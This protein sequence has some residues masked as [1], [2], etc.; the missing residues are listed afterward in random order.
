MLLSTD[1][2]EYLTALYDFL[3]REHAINLA[4]PTTPAYTFQE[5]PSIGKMPIRTSSPKATI[6]EEGTL[7]CK[8]TLSHESTPLNLLQ[9]IQAVIDPLE[10]YHTFS[11]LLMSYFNISFH[12]CQL[13]TPR[14]TN[15]CLWTLF[16][17]NPMLL[18]YIPR[19]GLVIP[20]YT[21]FSFLRLCFTAVGQRDLLYP[22]ITDTTY[23]STREIDILFTDIPYSHSTMLF[24]PFSLILSV[25][26]YLPFAFQILFRSATPKGL[27]GVTI[28]CPP[29][30]TSICYTRCLVKLNSYVTSL[31][32]TLP[33]LP[34]IYRRLIIKH[35]VDLSNLG[36]CPNSIKFPAKAVSNNQISEIGSTLNRA[37]QSHCP[38]ATSI[39]SSVQ[40]FEDLN[41][42]ML[43]T[44]SL[45]QSP[46]K[47]Y[48]TSAGPLMTPSEINLRPPKSS[49]D[50]KNGPRIN[51]QT[52][53]QTLFVLMALKQDKSDPSR[54]METHETKRPPGLLRNLDYVPKILTTTSLSMDTFTAYKRVDK[55]VKPVS[56]TFPEDYYIHRC[57]SKDPL[58]TLLPIP[59]HPPEFVP[60]SKFSKDCME[61]LNV[62]ST[63]FLWPEEEKLFKYIMNLNEEAIA[64]EDAERGTLKESYFSPYIIPTVPHIPWK[65]KH[66]PIAPGLRNKVM[67]VLRLKIAAGVY[68]QSSSSYRS[69]WFVVLK[70]NGKLCIV[71]DLQLLNKI[72]IRDAGTLPILDDFVEN[73]AGRQCYTVFDLFWGF[74]AHK[75]HPK[76]RELT[77]FST[78]LGT[79]QLTSLPTRFTNSP[80]EFQKCMTIILQDEIPT[81]ANIFIDDLPIKG[82]VT[83]Y[84]DSEGKPEVLKENPGIRCFIWEHAHNVHRIM[85]KIKCAGA[86]FAANKAQI[87]SPEVLIVG[88]TCN[89]KER[90]PD[91]TKVDKILTWPKL[92]TPKEVHQFLGLCG[93]V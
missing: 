75:I 16:P 30:I 50:Q 60:T 82:P 8:P 33:N 3:L 14:M 92:T 25:T 85:H 54:I 27:K 41:C 22:F 20:F 80:A 42:G 62:N 71:H 44:V 55:K 32:D 24:Y 37:V 77:T 93:T 87:C 73:F 58:L 53:S 81:K 79:L 1:E 57:I 26:F 86:T 51:S 59:Y 84:L 40:V 61:I 18:L 11:P 34:N 4:Q 10:R 72:T 15:V 43:W 69:P 78:P 70:K 52:H 23:A 83:Q 2:A 38:E 6:C 89:S 90:S 7:R 39:S 48:K 5:P 19:F 28:V 65:C 88:Q 17:S 35:H 29:S 36:R 21:R 49:L 12:A 56:T 45:A 46:I 67:D 68:E 13:Y 63:N 66:I 47:P 74:D 64:F 9:S 91:D 31:E 76:S